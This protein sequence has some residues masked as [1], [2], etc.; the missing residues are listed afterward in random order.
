VQ[1]PL[2]WALPVIAVALVV[3]AVDAAL[4]LVLH[5]DDAKG[6]VAEAAKIE[7]NR[8]AV[9]DPRK[10]R[11]VGDVV[12]G[13]LPTRIVAGSG[14]VWVLNRGDG[15]VS[16]IDP[17]TRRLVGTLDPGPVVSDITMGDGG[18]WL[19]GRP[20]SSSPQTPQDVEIERVDPVSGVVN[21]DF[22][23]ETGAF[24]IAAAGGALWTTGYFGPGY[25]GTAR[26]DPKTGA[27]SRLDPEVYGELIAADDRSVFWVS[28]GSQAARVETHSPAVAA[29][30]HLATN[31][32]LAAGFVPPQPTGVTLG[33]GSLWI[34]TSGGTV[35]R[36]DDKLSRIVSNERV[37]P[38]A[39]GIS[40]GEG[41]VW[42]ACG[43]N[44]VVPLDPSSGRPGDA[45]DVGHLP[46]GVA[47][48]E[49][50]VWV[51]LD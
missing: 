18:V 27:F 3:A 39:L 50:A 11:V 44:T 35:V 10:H 17:R 47:A 38:S 16:H 49:G 46:R 42:V 26:S 23:S 9:I 25:R 45:I 40:Y 21:R 24:S 22:P 43:D 2:R 31:E 36:V 19:T 5:H 33:A 4:Y 37:C 29:H 6:A 51:T 34:S 28:L 15:T 13:Y 7:A 20:R 32:S 8:V 48:G 14:A 1:R 30:L 12:V 41:A